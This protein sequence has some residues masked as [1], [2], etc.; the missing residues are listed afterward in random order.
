MT[1]S[2]V[3]RYTFEAAH[4]LPAL[5]E[6]HK[7]RRLYGHSFKLWVTVARAAWRWRRE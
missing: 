7:C 2:I 6:E 1:V 5:P 4:Q 3:R